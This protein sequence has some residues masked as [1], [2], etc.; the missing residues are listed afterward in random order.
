MYYVVLSLGSNK[1]N[2]E[3]YIK[4]MIKN[5]KEVIESPYFLSTLMETEPVDVTEKQE[6]YLNQI[7]MGRYEGSAYELLREC[8]NIEIKLGREEKGTYSSRTAD[9]DI[10]LFG[11]E[12]IYTKELTIPHHSLFRRRFCIE[13]TLEVLKEAKIDSGIT[14][15]LFNAYN[16]MPT[17]IKRQKIIHKQKDWLV[18]RR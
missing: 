15:K 16:N 2:R 5:L 18:W 4:E 7:I 10:L 11:E 6:W 8:Q 12:E 14:E 9:I 13:G 3:F 1:G 17:V